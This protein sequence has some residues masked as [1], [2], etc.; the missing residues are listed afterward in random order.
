MKHLLRL[1]LGLAAA[2]GL[3]LS[4]PGV[5]HASADGPTLC[6]TGSCVWFDSDGE[7]FYLT[8]TSADG[9]SAA[10]EICAPTLPN[11][12]IRS[13]RIWNSDGHGTTLNYDDSY[14]EGTTVYYRPCIGEWNGG[15]PYTLACNSGWTH[16]TA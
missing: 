15:N 7:H 5:A 16:G 1:L 14:A 3:L 10:A 9:H 6:I 8:D 2:F 11:C 13:I 12:T 4:G